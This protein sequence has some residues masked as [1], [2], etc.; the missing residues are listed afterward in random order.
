MNPVLS[1]VAETTLPDLMMDMVALAYQTDSTRILSFMF[2]NAGSN[3][4]YKEIG[5]NE[6]HHELSHHGKSE[7]KQARSSRSKQKQAKARKSKQYP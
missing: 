4:A 5:V 1:A 2:T 6:G 7:H 3:R